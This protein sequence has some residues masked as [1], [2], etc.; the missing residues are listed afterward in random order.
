MADRY[1]SIFIVDAYL[2]MLSLVGNFVQKYCFFAKYTNIQAKIYF[3]FDFCNI[4]LTKLYHIRK[5]EPTNGGF[6][7]CTKK[8]GSCYLVPPLG[9]DGGSIAVAGEDTRVRRKGEEALKGSE[10]LVDITARK[11][12]ATIAHTEKSVA[13][14]EH[15]VLREIETDRTRGVTGRVKKSER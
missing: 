13:R 1:L 15:F 5:I 3:L 4:C 14:E 11:V 9:T 12:G 7:Y 6:F 10:E 8:T 2:K